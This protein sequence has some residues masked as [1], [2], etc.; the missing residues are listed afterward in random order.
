MS[1]FDNAKFVQV[2]GGLVA[3][4]WSFIRSL[5]FYRDTQQTKFGSI[6][7]KIDG[8]AEA[9]VVETYH[10]YVEELKRGNRN[11]PGSKLSH[12]QAV[13]ARNR[14]RATAMHSAR[15]AGID[16]LKIIGEDGL[17]VAI[18]YAIKRQKGRVE[19]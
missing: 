13:I 6:L 5:E 7:Q 9:A 17:A 15:E 10:G 4:L 2:I 16:I 14:A 1:L 8:I 18:E 12:E 11:G 19:A 3:L